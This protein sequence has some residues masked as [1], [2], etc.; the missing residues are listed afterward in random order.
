VC[1]VGG[2]AVAVLVLKAGGGTPC[3]LAL[4]PAY[5]PPDELE[6]LA[7]QPG[8]RRVVVVNPASGPGDARDPRYADAIAALRE[9]DTPVL[10]YVATG[11]ADRPLALAEA[12]IE[13]YARWY[14]V[15]G[16]FLDEAASDEARLG[17]FARLADVVRETTGGM[18]VLNPGTMPDAAYF[19]VADVVVTFE[20]SYADY[21]AALAARPRRI[22][23][24]P[25]AKRA[26]LV[27]GATRDQALQAA[28]LDSG[29]GFFYATSGEQPNPWRV[30]PD[31]LPALEDA[32]SASTESGE[33]RGGGPCAST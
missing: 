5:V 2:L 28:G 29:A 23:R 12:D 16:A 14:G 1:S 13:R 18:V 7:E 26:H 32:L 31:D 9:G 6:R 10:G 33:L 11:W 22:S 24:I 21:R 19:D 4:V 27:Y 15:D 17:Y 30:V 25:G 8:E 3:R 20:G